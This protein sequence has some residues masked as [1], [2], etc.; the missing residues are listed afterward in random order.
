MES[1]IITYASAAAARNQAIAPADAEQAVRLA[2]FVLRLVQCENASG[3]AMNIPAKTWKCS[4]AS[5]KRVKER[6]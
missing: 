5:G 2:V 3:D 4:T 1:P 6:L